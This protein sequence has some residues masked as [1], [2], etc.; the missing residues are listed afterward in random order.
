M[1]HEDAGMLAAYLYARNNAAVPVRFSLTLVN[2][3]DAKQSKVWGEISRVVFMMH[4]ALL[5]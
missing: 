2:H 5:R 4:V 3:T 1:I